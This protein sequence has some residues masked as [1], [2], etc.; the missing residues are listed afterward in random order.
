ML[1]NHT[2]AG[3]LLNVMINYTDNTVFDDMNGDSVDG[4]DDDETDTDKNQLKFIDNN[5][6]ND[7]LLVHDR[8][9]CNNETNFCGNDHRFS[10]Q[11]NISQTVISED[12]PNRMTIQRKSDSFVVRRPS[13]LNLKQLVNDADAKATSNEQLNCDVDDV[14]GKFWERKPLNST[15]DA[16]PKRINVAFQNLVYTTKRGFCW[17]RGNFLTF[18]LKINFSYKH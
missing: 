7:L 9:N 4:D 16:T 5:D 18:F 2:S 6:V 13:A 14:D 8:L 15:S 3:K 12:I 11:S 1:P 10:K 17:N